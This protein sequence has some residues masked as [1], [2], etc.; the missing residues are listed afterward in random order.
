MIKHNKEG[1]KGR[2]GG[3]L[4]CLINLTV[5]FVFACVVVAVVGFV[6]F[7]WLVGVCVCVCVC[8]H[9]HILYRG[10]LNVFVAMFYACTYY[11]KR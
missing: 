8:V 10:V 6:L 3:L 2:G 11:V 5:C 9:A 7:C 4:S 1:V